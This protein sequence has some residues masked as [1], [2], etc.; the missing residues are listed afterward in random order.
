MPPNRLLAAVAEVNG[1]EAKC[2][3]WV[4]AAGPIGR[5]VEGTFTVHSTQSD[6]NAALKPVLG[7]PR[8]TLVPQRGG[9][10]LL[11]PFYP[12]TW[13]PLIPLIDYLAVALCWR[14]VKGG[15]CAER[16]L[17]ECVCSR[18]MCYNEPEGAGTMAACWRLTGRCVSAPRRTASMRTGPQRHKC[19]AAKSRNATRSGTAGN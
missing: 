10:N 8:G 13:N 19:H 1:C 16:C 18:V 12:N 5:T 11:V 15:L 9:P 17:S 2:R 4:C 6:P 3:K 7:S 14:R